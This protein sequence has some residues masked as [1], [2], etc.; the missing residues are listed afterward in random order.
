MGRFSEGILQAVPFS[1]RS[2][3]E[4][5][6]SSFLFPN[7]DKDCPN[8]SPGYYFLLTNSSR[9]SP[10]LHFVSIGWYWDRFSEIDK[11]WD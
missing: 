4:L 10:N 2:L 6:L 8:F 1:E 3:N 5:S 7:G 11:N 9:D